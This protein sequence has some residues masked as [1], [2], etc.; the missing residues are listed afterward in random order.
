M[1][2]SLQ[3]GGE[4]YDVQSYSNIDYGDIPVYSPNKVDLG[5]LEPDGQFELSDALD[6][7]PSVG[8]LYTGNISN[9]CT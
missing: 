8:Q 3:A 9:G 6:F 1:T 7:R 4:F 2:T 5:G